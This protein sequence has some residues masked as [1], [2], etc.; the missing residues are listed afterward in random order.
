MVMVTQPK[1]E[2]TEP[3]PKQSELPPRSCTDG[4]LRVK[5]RIFTNKVSLF[6]VLELG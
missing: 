4:H 6:L 5:R 3:E 2:K 1:S